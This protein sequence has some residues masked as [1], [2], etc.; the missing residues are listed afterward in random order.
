MKFIDNAPDKEQQI[1]KR[2][3]SQSQLFSNSLSTIPVK[4]GRISTLLMQVH[5]QTSHLCQIVYSREIL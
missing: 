2:V 3:H 4:P 5:F 1:V